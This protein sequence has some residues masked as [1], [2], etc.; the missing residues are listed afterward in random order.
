MFFEKLF[1]KVLT[2]SCVQVIIHRQI[3]KYWR[4]CYVHFYG[5]S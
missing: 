4:K 2:L 1:E 3:K 5:K